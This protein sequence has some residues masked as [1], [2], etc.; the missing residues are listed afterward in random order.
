M[1][2]GMAVVA[3]GNAII[4]AGLHDLLEFQ[5]A[6]MPSGVRKT[7]LQESTAPAATKIVGPIGGHVDEIIFPHHGFDYEPQIF[8]NGVSK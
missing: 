3:G 1:N 8:G 7:G 5:A 4:R 6:V 2:L